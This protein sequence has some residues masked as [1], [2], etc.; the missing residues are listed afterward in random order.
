MQAFEHACIDLHHIRHSAGV[1]VGR[2]REKLATAK[3]LQPDVVALVGIRGA[4]HDDMHALTAGR[5]LGERS[6]RCDDI[7]ASLRHFTGSRIGVSNISSA[8]LVHY[9]I[10]TTSF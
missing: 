9:V 7:G 5:H 8:P 2:E 6:A 1:T 10:T 4:L 3:H